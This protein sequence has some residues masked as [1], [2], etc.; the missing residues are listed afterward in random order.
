[1]TNTDINVA[2]HKA[3]GKSIPVDDDRKWEV[4]PI[5]DGTGRRKYSSHCGRCRGTG[6]L[7][8][9]GKRV[10]NYCGDLN[11]MHEA[12]ELFYGRAD[13]LEGAERMNTFSRLLCNEGY[14]LH[15][16]ALQRAKAFLHTLG[17][18]VNTPETPE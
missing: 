7:S 9:R 5:C 6:R 2:I 12:E 14:P 15:S 8:V 17:L 3:L 13:T 1:M 10:P 18:W 16:T 4:C 11:A